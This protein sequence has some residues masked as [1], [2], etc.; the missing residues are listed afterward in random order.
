M[1][2]P[3]GASYVSVRTQCI[4]DGF[5]A[6]NFVGAKQIGFSEGGQHC[7]ERLGAPDFLAEVLECMRQ[8]VAYRKPE[9]AQ[10][11]RAQKY[12]QLVLHAHGAVLQIAIIKTEARVDEDFFEPD[13]LRKLKLPLEVAL[14]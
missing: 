14:H 2:F 6:G 5:Y 11:K 8:R 4:E 1:E 7:E 9:R 10:T 13:L 3:A 12:V